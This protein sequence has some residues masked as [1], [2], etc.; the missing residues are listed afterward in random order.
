MKPFEEQDFFEHTFEFEHFKCKITNNSIEYIVGTW[1]YAIPG[2]FRVWYNQYS[3]FDP[4]WR[5]EVLNI[6][7]GYMRFTA[8]LPHELEQCLSM[9]AKVWRVPIKY[10]EIVEYVNGPE[11][12]SGISLPSDHEILAEKMETQEFYELMQEYRHHKDQLHVVNA[13]NNVKK[14]I[15]KQI[16]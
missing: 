12:A 8:F 2:N 7:N 15:L 11:G 9:F 13:F 5:S 1:H 16:K 4:K 14:W 10:K 3:A 6:E